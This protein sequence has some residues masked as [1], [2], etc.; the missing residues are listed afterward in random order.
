[1][2]VAVHSKTS[3][4][5]LHTGFIYVLIL[6]AALFLH[7]C[8]SHRNYT[9]PQDIPVYSEYG[10]ASYYSMKFQSKKTAS[11]ERFDNNGMTAAHNS[12]PFGTKVLVTNIHNGRTVVVTINDRGP[13]IRGRIIDLS[14]AAFAKIENLK[15]GITEVR[16]TVV[17]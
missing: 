17:N 13:H 7:G 9:H 15:R 16:I 14:R 2:K 1:M 12:L 5:A 3:R 11:G 8:S 4:D 6:T 10:K